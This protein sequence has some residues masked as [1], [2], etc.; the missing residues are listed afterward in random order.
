MKSSYKTLLFIVSISLP[1]TM[2]RAIDPVSKMQEVSEQQK[3]EKPT[4]R[5]RA[6]IWVGAITGAAAVA[7]AAG[8]YFR[9]RSKSEPEITF[10]SAHE[11]VLKPAYVGEINEKELVKK[12]NATENLNELEKLH[13]QHPKYWYQDD[14]VAAYLAQR[15]KLIANEVAILKQRV[16]SAQ[17]KTELLDMKKDVFDFGTDDLVRS[18]IDRYTQ[19]P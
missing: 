8:I 3:Q 5:K 18:W 2:I 1:L 15:E 6:L 17:T 7:T 10:I 16:L 4:L 11:N 9:S 13:N 19:L 14:A 12:I